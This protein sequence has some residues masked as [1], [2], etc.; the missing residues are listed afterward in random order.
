M[1]FNV[2][3]RDL[4]VP[5]KIGITDEE[6]QNFQ[7]I[8]ISFSGFIAVKDDDIDNI[9]KLLNYS[10]LKKLIFDNAHNSFFKTLERLLVELKKEIEEKFPSIEEIN[11][12]INKF[13]IAKKYNASEV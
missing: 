1:K 13:D 9:D 6:R 12:K 8:Y 10:N 3:I 4:L 11:L 2:V 5:V 7:N